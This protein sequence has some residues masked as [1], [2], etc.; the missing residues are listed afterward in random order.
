MKFYHELDIIN[1]DNITISFFVLM[2]CIVEM[3]QTRIANN[4]CNTDK[5]VLIRDY[6]I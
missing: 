3:C 6:L 4:V 1:V 2:L 5:V